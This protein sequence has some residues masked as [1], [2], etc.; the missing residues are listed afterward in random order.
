AL[1][2]GPRHR[3]APGRLRDFQLGRFRS[4]ASRTREFIE[5]SAWGRQEDF[6]RLSDADKTVWKELARAL[7]GD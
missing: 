5:R 7:R 3:P 1:R 2:A 6:A 4:L